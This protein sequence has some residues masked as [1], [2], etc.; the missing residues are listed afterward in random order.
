MKKQYGAIAVGKDG[1]HV[2]PF[3]SIKAAADWTIKHRAFELN[4]FIVIEHPDSYAEWLV[5]SSD[6]VIRLEK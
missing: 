5:K 4:K 2:G 3:N 6:N 1:S